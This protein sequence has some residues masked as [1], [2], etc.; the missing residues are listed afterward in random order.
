MPAAPSP[1]KPVSWRTPAVVLICGC[2]LAVIAFGPRSTLGFF[3]TPITSTHGWGRDIFGFAL[4][5]QNIIWGAGQPFSGALA[6]RF[7]TIPVIWV[8]AALY[9]AGLAMM[10]YATTPGML[11]ISA[12]VLIG[13]GLSG[14]SFPVV[15][16]ALGKLLPDRMRPLAFG[17]GTAAG[18]FGQFLY[19][20]L[21]V[22]LIDQYGWQST[23]FIMAASLILV[24]PLSLALASPRATE[25]RTV[26]SAPS[27]SITHALREALAHRSYV[28]LVLGYF[29]CGFQLQFVTIHLPSFL[30][31]RGLSAQVGGWTIAV[32]GLFNI[33]GSIAS[34]WLAGVFPKRYLLSLIYFTRALAILAFISFPVTPTTCIIFGAVMGLMWLSTVPP[35]TSLIA[36]MFGTRWLAM[37]TGFAFFSHQVGGFLGVLLGG[38]AFERTGSYDLMWWLAILFGVLSALINLPIVEKPVARPATAGASA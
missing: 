21:A 17:A 22:A 4:A 38:I 28:L 13:F 24:L 7:G 5:L 33:V 26:A 15:L 25:T 29:T 27:Q 35:T 30:V 32:I 11:D 8:G 2:F 37:L 23:L 19:S 6:D 3:L 14:C 20:P 16:A 18:S 31:D 12:G 10:A 1:S 36:V 9:A 34:G